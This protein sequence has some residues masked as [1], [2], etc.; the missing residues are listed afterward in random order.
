VRLAHG[1]RTVRAT[2]GELLYELRGASPG[3]ASRTRRV[4]PRHVDGSLVFTIP[5]GARV[6]TVTLVVAN[7][8]TTQSL[9]YSVAV[10]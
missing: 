1:A 7:G 2:R 4:A 5:R 6:G 9:P 8:R 10:D 3:D